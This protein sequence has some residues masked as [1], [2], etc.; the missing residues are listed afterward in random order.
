[1]TS[2]RWR[3]VEAVYHAA[4]ARVVGDR[5]SFLAEACAGDDSLRREVESLLA[6]EQEASL[7]IE[8]PAIEVAAIG[9]NN[10]DRL[11]VGRQMGP[12]TILSLLGA[13]GMGEVY[14]AHDTTLGR[15]VA[16]KVLPPVFTLD[17]ERR[18]RFE[19]EAR[20]LASLNHPH[21]AAIYGVEDAGGV[22][23]LVLELVEGPTLAERLAKRALPLGE[24]LAIARQIA[25]ALE[26]AHDKGIIHRDLKP[27]NVKITPE[28]LVKVLDFGLARAAASDAAADVSQPATSLSA[29]HDGVVLGTAAYMS[30][31]QARGQLLDKRTDIWA[32]GCLLYEM[33]S[34]RRAFTGDTSSEAMAAVLERDPAW[35]ALPAA[36]P[37]NIRTLIERCLEKDLKLRLRDIGDA[38]LEI[39]RA[40]A[41]SSGVP[42][43]RGPYR[44][45]RAWPWVLLGTLGAGAGLA[46]FVT[47]PVR[48]SPSLASIRV[49]VD[50]GADASLVTGLYG[51]GVAA[52]LSPDGRTLA[53]VGRAGQGKSLLY[54]RSLEQL[55]A[56]PLPGTE[57]ALNPFFSPDGQWIAFFADGKLKKILATGAG[58]LTLC[59]AS[60][61]RGGAWAEDGTIIFSPKRA[62]TSLWTVSDAGG[63]PTSM[64][65]LDA[66]EVTQRWPQVLPGRKGILYTSHNNPNGF[67][68]ANV[69]VQ[70]LP[71]GA[72][73]VLVR[74]A[75]DG[76]YIPTGHLIYVHDSTLFAVP[77]DLN[78]LEVTG[79][80]I[81]VLDGVAVS[82]PVGAAQIAISRTGTLVYL[83]GAA[84]TNDAPIDWVDRSGRVTPMRAAP[85][86]WLNHAFSP[87]GRKLAMT[88]YDGKQWGI[89]MYDWGRDAL[90]R[91]TYD[92]A[93]S[94]VNPV[95]TPDGRRIV[96]ASTRDGS[97]TSNLNLFWQRTDGTG[98]AQRLTDGSYEQVPASSDPS[99]RLIAFAERR[100]DTGRDVMILRID[101]DEQ[102]GW[103]PGKPTVFLNS[104]FSETEPVFSPDGR[105]LAYVS[106]ETGRDEVY[107]RPFPGPGGKRQISTGGGS[108]PTWSRA[109]HEL[110][111]GTPDNRIMVASY[112]SQGDTFR[113]EKPRLGSNVR[114]SPRVV[115]KSFDVHPDGERFALTAEREPQGHEDTH[116][117]TLIFNFFDELRRMASTVTR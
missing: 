110:F 3:Q 84:L 57:G 16:I 62:G 2:E 114:F 48:T 28:G 97:A 108:G 96:F 69:V 86:F 116:H 67:D 20:L 38:R 53:F 65:S 36:T 42:P 27:A 71:R 63:T 58:P 94:A 19:R 74:G 78:H 8:Q 17:P 83:S 115:G 6:H 93:A 81:R 104:R 82:P 79:P 111:Y 37:E 102:S 68:D 113:A 5:A 87:D 41:M 56:V 105:W 9:L 92:V 90:S 72:R 21:I 91:L 61:N 13:G 52:I 39:D 103:K 7:F 23:G 80:A 24:A 50:L 18:A 29:D 112:S 44:R 59:N 109:R 34:G 107:V 11:P 66:G 101:G 77:F 98:E 85:A 4:A 40:I 99:G 88:I 26:A 70:P 47:R 15:D 35:K 64:T 117:V 76:R 60:D 10:Q 14:R 12:Y 30:P 25:D 45:R 106:N 43:E 22:R 31:Q 54:V 51:Q 49:S 100:P 46:I 33:L 32:F 75:Y 55:R 1:M 89:W 95:W 73:K